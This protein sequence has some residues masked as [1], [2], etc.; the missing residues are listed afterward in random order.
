M[1]YYAFVEEV[2]DIKSINNAELRMC[3][4]METAFA[5]SIMTNTTN[6]MAAVADANGEIL[7]ID[8]KQQLV[9]I[10]WIMRSDFIL[11]EILNGELALSSHDNVPY[12]TNKHMILVHCTGNNYAIAN[13]ADYINLD[14]IKDEIHPATILNRMVECGVG[15]FI[16]KESNKLIFK[17]LKDKFAIEGSVSD[18]AFVPD[19]DSRIIPDGKLLVL[20]GAF[21]NATKMKFIGLFSSVIKLYEDVNIQNP[22]WFYYVQDSSKKFHPV[23]NPKI[24][25][26][27][28]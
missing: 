12:S 19:M 24:K 15:P 23:F 13:T 17:Y 1:K 28:L 2:K 14:K 5:V 18:K 11:V 16:F 25:S 22:I 3:P 26:V 20:N 9:K 8:P 7:T 4:T 27:D 10:D 21:G 6:P